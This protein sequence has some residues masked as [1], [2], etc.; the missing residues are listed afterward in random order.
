MNLIQFDFNSY[1]FNSAAQIIIG[2]AFLTYLLRIKNKT[3]AIRI[4]SIALTGFTLSVTGIFIGNIVFWGG[5]SRALTETCAVFSMAAMISFCYHY[6]HKVNSLEAKIVQGAALATTYLSLF[7]TINYSIKFFNGQPLQNSFPS[8]FW[9]LNPLVFFATILICL[10]RAFHFHR[11]YSVKKQSF[12]KDMLDTIRRPSCRQANL[13]RNYALVISF[14]M[15]QGFVSLLTIANII[16]LL[17]SA[18]FIKT[19]MLIMIIG[20][21]YA[22]FELL[23]RQPGLIVR[24]EGLFL[25][26]L[27]GILATLGIFTEQIISKQIIEEHQKILNTIRLAIKQKNFNVLPSEI[28]YILIQENPRQKQAQLIYTAKEGLN[29]SGLIQESQSMDKQYPIWGG[30][31]EQLLLFDSKSVPVQFRY[32][33]HPFGS[34]HEFA[35]FQ[36]TENGSAYEAGFDLI[37]MQKPLQQQGLAMIWAMVLS[38]FFIL[39]IFP[40]FFKSNL[41][42]PLERLLAGVKQVDQGNLKISIPL[43]HND[44]IGF[45]T[46]AFNTLASSLQNELEHRNIAETKLREVNKTLEQR[47]TNRTRELEVLYDVSAAASQA[48]ELQALLSVSLKR[49][50]SALNCYS[51]AIFL[52]DTEPSSLPKPVNSRRMYMITCQGIIAEWMPQMETLFSDQE[53]I[54]ILIKQDEPLLIPDTSTDSRLPQFLNQAKPATLV[55][56]PLHAENQILGV[57]SLFHAIKPGLKLDEVALL[58][59]IASQ[60]GGAIH[61]EHL[62]Q[63]AQQATILEERQQLTRNLHDSVIQS[64]YGLVTLS[65][66]GQIKTETWDQA[67]VMHTFNRIGKTARQS[68]REIRL[69]IHQLRPP[70]LEQEGLINALDLRL[71]AVEGRSD[72]QVNLQIDE[73]LKLAPEIETAFYHIAQEALNNILKHAKAKSLKINLRSVDQNV[74]LEICDDGCGFDPHKTESGGL[75][76][77]NMQERINAINGELTIHSKP[78]EG[79]LIKAKAVVKE[80]G[81]N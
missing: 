18:F 7:I 16:T 59:S 30:F 6:P 55:L 74:I 41:I 5:I 23:P 36:F 20:A 77:N 21:V 34:Y 65:E 51:G 32:G 69:F 68:I 29:W 3:P 47:V 76:L 14:G 33:N 67:Y 17:Q 62:R 52:F 44:E 46:S 10:Y 1:T 28:E 4:I 61:T 13:L 50:M 53:I 9:Y 64:L 71:A 24:L 78:G 43:T 80:L 49:T 58:T 81:T 26:T 60:V 11:S 39:G 22:S 8:F 45:L 70:M 31:F 54:E 73:Y 25:V 75:G 19:T 57:L 38:S 79:T 63:R 66:A 48:Y 40:Y 12:W 27:L 72:I 37:E 42:Y 56:V 35:A 15:V 2:V